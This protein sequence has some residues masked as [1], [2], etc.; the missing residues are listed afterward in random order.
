MWK[1]IDFDVNFVVPEVGYDESPVDPKFWKWTQRVTHDIVKPDLK[2]KKYFGQHE[3]PRF[4]L[5][6]LMYVAAVVVV[7][8]NGA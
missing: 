5:I 1:F 2:K 3:S 4:Q 6:G 8:D 7:A